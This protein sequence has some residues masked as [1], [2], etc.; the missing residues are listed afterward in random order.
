MTYQASGAGFGPQQWELS[1]GYLLLTN[2]A[3]M[4]SGYFIES[5][6][7][8]AYLQMLKLRYEQ[9]KTNIVLYNILPKSQSVIRSLVRVFCDKLLLP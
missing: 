7:R 1:L 6:V 8:N 2:L 9:Y 4:I 3:M 5:S